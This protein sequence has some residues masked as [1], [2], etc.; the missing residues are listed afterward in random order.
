MTTTLDRPS[1]RARPP[2]R[3]E[4]EVVRGPRVLGP[5]AALRAAVVGLLAVALPVLLVWATDSRSG[6]GA[7]EAL[8]SGARF[9][10]VAHG[11]SLELTDS[12]VALTPLGLLLLP[13]LL[14]S[15]AAAAAA[16]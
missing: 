6:A 3:T 5:T 13:L 12:R 2:R 9:W 8:R 10:L 15:G 7:A 16:R 1:R 11:A 14:V 4:A